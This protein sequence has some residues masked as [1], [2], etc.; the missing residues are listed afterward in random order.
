MIVKIINYKISVETVYRFIF[1]F[2]VYIYMNI[3]TVYNIHI[4]MYMALNISN[5]C[6]RVAIDR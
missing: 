3:S 6:G 1:V 5:I 2:D 4:Y